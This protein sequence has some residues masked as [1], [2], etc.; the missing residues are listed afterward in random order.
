MIFGKICGREPMQPPTDT[1][2]GCELKYSESPSCEHH[3][4]LCCNCVDIACK[5]E[6]RKIMHVK[7]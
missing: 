7:E 6:G 5:I 2:P 1:C 3:I 4:G